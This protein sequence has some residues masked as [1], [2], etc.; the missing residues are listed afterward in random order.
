MHAEI[1]RRRIARYYRWLDRLTW[2]TETRRQTGNEAQPVHRALRDP[3]GGPASAAVVHRLMLD[4]LA[5]PAAPRVLDAGCGYGATSIELAPRLGGSWL[6]VTLSP[7]QAARGTAEAAKRGLGERV[8]FAVQSYDDALPGPFDLAIAIESLIHSV[9]PAA[10]IANIAASLAPGG[11]LVVVDDMPEPGLEP[12]DAADLALFRRMWRCPVAP[13]VGAWRAAMAAAGLAI[14]AERDL[15]ALQL[16]R[17][18]EDLAAPLAR[19]RRRAFWLGLVGGGLREQAD[20][21]GMT[22]ELLHG[23]G[24]VRYRLMVGRRA[25]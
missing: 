13:E 6:G 4:G 1:Q 16:L 12:Q 8:R 19:Q 21:G 20:I 24:A 25:G 17:P 10:S 18:P 14:V 2:M 15:T 5:L 3:D 22:L 7:V 9:D 23:R 11:H